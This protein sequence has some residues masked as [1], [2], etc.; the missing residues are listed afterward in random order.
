MNTARFITRVMLRHYKS[1]ANCDVAL[2]ELTL[3]VGPNGAGKSNFLDAL[4]FVRDSLRESLDYA[5]RQRGGI[6]EVRRRS[7][8]H[9]THLGIRLDFG[10]DEFSGYHAFEVGALPSAGFKVAREQCVLMSPGRTDFF[11]VRDGIVSDCSITPSPPAVKDRLYLVNAAGLPAFRPLFDALST[12]G[13]YNLNPKLMGDLQEPDEGLLLNK[14]GSNLASVIAR[15]ERDGQSRKMRIAAYLNR[16]APSIHGFEFKPVGP[17]HS[18]EFRQDV[19]GQ[20]QPWRFWAASMSDGTLRALGLL[21]AVFQG[22]N[23]LAVRLVGIE[24]PEA[25]LH[26]AAAAVVLDSL[27]EAAES[28]QVIVTTHSAELLDR[29]RIKPEN[30]L[31]VINVNGTTHIGP[32]D[33]A[34]RNALRRSLFTAGELLRLNQL[35]PDR[36]LFGAIPVQ[37]ELFGEVR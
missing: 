12:M 22:G 30:L 25:A 26:P 37:A 4:C 15:L 7:G 13:F 28:T 16:V 14:F 10:F 36:P 23:G 29:E 32:V 9:P 31:A 24:E 1:I 8:G 17:K 6:N 11:D 34:S 27:H 21:T 20:K 2:S 33:E 19:E 3:L 35:A 5:V 18:L